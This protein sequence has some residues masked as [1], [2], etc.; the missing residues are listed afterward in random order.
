MKKEESRLPKN[1]PAL[2]FFT[3]TIVA[4]SFGFQGD[5][6]TIFSPQGR[7]VAE[8]RIFSIACHDFDKDGRLD[9]VVSDYLNPAR[10]LYND[11]RFE[12]KKALPLTSTAETAKTGHGVAL[13]D[14]NGDGHPDL[15]LV[16]NEFSERFLLG[17]GKGGFADSGQAIGKTA[18][19]GT[20]AKTAD[21]DGDGDLDVFVTYYQERT[22][23]YLNDGK[24]VFTESGQ[25]FDDDVEVGDFNGDGGIDVLSLKEGGL[26]ALWLNE[27]GR[28]VLQERTLDFGEGVFRLLPVDMDTDGDLDLFALGRAVK[29]A[30]WEN[31]GRGSFR[32]LE[33]TF[34]SGTRVAAGDI[35]LD[36]KKDLVSG[37]DIWINKGGGRFENVQTVSLGMTS[38]LELADIDGDGD[39]DLLGAGLDRVTGRA[40]LVL[41]LNGVRQR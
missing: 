27:K 15:F 2:I 8:G 19:S 3:L 7:L 29:S 10:I 26:A 6:G 37:S 36:G 12:F 21:I 1:H 38:A 30:L 4:L 39:L 9:I 22:R 13:G 34:S 25:T 20:T 33:Q 18:G 40:D 32:R 23:L 31:D 5:A 35:D 17:D 28:L 24:G 11:A 14:F 41:F 16:Y